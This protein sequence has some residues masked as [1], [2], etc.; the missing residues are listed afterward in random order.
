MRAGAVFRQVGRRFCRDRRGN[1]GMMMAV[2]APLLALAA[3]YGL[4]IAQISHARSNLLAALDAAVTST[5]RD[6]TTGA[7][8]E[9]DARETVEAF[10]FANGERGFAD[11]DR[12]SL[13][14]IVIDRTASTVSARASVVVDL[15]F[16][17]FGPRERTIS[18]ESAAVYSDKKIEI[19][20]MLDVTWS[21]NGQK[22]RDLRTAAA[23]AVDSFLGGQD[24]SKPRVRVALVPYATGVNTGTLSNTVF[25]EKEYTTGEPPRLDE[26]LP[27][28][29][30]VASDRCATE[31]KGSEQ[32]TDASPYQAMV[33]RDYRLDSC[34]QAALMPLTADA[35]SL[36]ARVNSLVAE[37]NGYTAGHIGVQWSWYLLSRNWADVLPV[38]AQPEPMDSK[39]VAKYAVLM[40]DGEFNTAFAGVPKNDQT[41]L[42]QGTRS[43][44]NAEKLCAAMKKDGIEIFTIGFQLSEPAAKTVMRNCASPDSGASKHYFE[45]STGEELDRA[46]QTIARNIERLALTR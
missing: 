11:A 6:L 38:S 28:A 46:Y 22:I 13:D 10:L 26:P 25:V 12:L 34:P 20:M 41:I 45:A 7:I 15:A 4:N 42:Y 36:R 27:A 43:R 1:F 30:G 18:T 24:P 44:T 14:S 32:F 9:A 17:L 40:T 33:N 29:A 19:A 31:R 21:M 39:K 35:A 3:G 16:P 5:A 8:K 23:N 37:R 2:V